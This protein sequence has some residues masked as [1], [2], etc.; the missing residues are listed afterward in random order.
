MF[1]KCVGS[2]AVDVEEV[3]HVDD[4]VDD[5]ATVGVRRR[6]CTSASRSTRRSSR[7]R[8]AGSSRPAAAGCARGRSRRTTSRPARAWSTSR[9][10]P[11]AGTRLLYGTFLHRPSPPQRQSW[12]GQAISS[13]LTSPW[14]QVAAHV[15][16]VAV[17]DVDLA[18]AATEDH[19]L[20]AERV[21]RVWLPVTE[22][23]GQTQAV[24][25]A[26]EA[27]RRRF[28]FDLPN[29]VGSG[30]SV[31]DLFYRRWSALRSRSSRSAGQQCAPSAIE[32]PNVGP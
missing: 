22:I 3:R 14:R 21:D 4:V 12:K 26:G 11:A 32:R 19:Q 17:E 2:D 23:F 20:L 29:L 10:G 13:P 27:C 1:L 28:G 9:C 6:W 15:P 25:S 5:L 24:P 31:M 8:S 30:C 7:P 18:V 16:A